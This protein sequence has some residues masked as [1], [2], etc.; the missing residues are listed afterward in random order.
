[1]VEPT[2]ETPPT[3]VVEPTVETPP[4]NVVEP[5][6]ETPPTNVVEP[7]VEI[8]PTQVVE[9]VFDVVSS[10]FHRPLISWDRASARITN[11][12]LLLA[13]GSGAEIS[14]T[15]GGVNYHND[16]ISILVSGGLPGLLIYA[17]F[18]VYLGSISLLIA[19]PFLLPGLVNAFL[20]SPQFVIL[21]SILSGIV[22]RHKMDSRLARKHGIDVVYVTIDQ[23]QSIE[24]SPVLKSQIGDAALSL[25]SA[26]YNVGLVANVEDPSSNV[27]ETYD[28]QFA[29][30][31]TIRNASLP[32]MLIR[33]AWNIY[34]LNRRH[35]IDKLYVRGIWGAIAAYI[36]FPTQYG[37]EIIYDY[38]GDIV[39]EAR[40]AGTRGIRLLLLRLLTQLIIRPANRHLSVSTQGAVNLEKNY[41]VENVTVIPSS[42]QV[43][44]FI[45]ATDTRT[46]IREK[47]GFSN[48]DVVCIYSGGLARYQMIPEMLSIWNSIAGPNVKFLL[49]TNDLPVHNVD[50]SEFESTLP[51]GTTMLSLDPDEVP[52]HLAAADIGFI[53]RQSDPLNTVASPVKFAEYLGA[54]LAVITSPGVNDIAEQVTLNKLGIVMSPNPSPSELA[55]LHRFV[56]NYSEQQNQIRHKAISLAQS[57]YD[58]STYV[59]NWR[60][61]IFSDDDPEIVEPTIPVRAD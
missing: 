8:S 39:A 51:P 23:G 54:G 35:S 15:Y 4:T 24:N 16:W 49:L 11:P 40:N 41:G 38:R 7:T 58:W 17:I 13:T 50:R 26:G 25:V 60:R 36:A 27:F 2:V 59:E 33:S 31:R 28:Q 42:T 43:S 12:P 56:G 48:D 57:H 1:V 5:T 44:K 30:V 3:N 20:F 21:I 6:V 34:K 10:P 37:P 47:L 32:L 19:L 61:D 18:V 14:P 46:A 55:L 45:S 53:L 29:E 22:M 9:P 52:T